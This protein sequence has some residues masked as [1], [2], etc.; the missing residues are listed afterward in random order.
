MATTPMTGM[1]AIRRRTIYENTRYRPPR[2]LRLL[3]VPEEH[4]GCH[5]HAL[6]VAPIGRGD[7]EH[8]GPH[9]G[10]ALERLGLDLLRDLLL[11]GKVGRLEPLADQR[12]DVEILR[13]AQ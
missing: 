12:L 3:H 13:P 8:A 2:T 10:Y 1:V 6:E 5:D 7:H 9:V 11:R 4:H